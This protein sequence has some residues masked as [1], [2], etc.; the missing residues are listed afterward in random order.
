MVKLR[1]KIPKSNEDEVTFNLARIANFP[2]GSRAQIRRAPMTNKIL[3]ISF[4]NVSNPP[5][6]QRPDFTV[7][8]VYQLCKGKWQPTDEYLIGFY[9]GVDPSHVSQL[10]EILDIPSFPKEIF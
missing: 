1:V 3:E 5:K 6:N 7:S 4:F 8:R 10:G 2:R 9:H